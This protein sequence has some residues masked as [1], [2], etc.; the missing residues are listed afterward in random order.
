MNNAIEHRVL[1]YLNTLEGGHSKSEKL[2]KKKLR[3]EEYFVDSRFSR[4]DV[5][6]LLAL[7]TRM[8]RTIKS[9][10]PAQNKND[11][12]C[13][14]CHVQVDCQQHLPSCIEPSKHATVPIDMKYK[15][16]FGNTEKQLSI[17]GV[18]ANFSQTQ[19]ADLP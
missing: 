10:F 17:K 9:N 2:A 19:K 15:D 1:H 11:I 7:R 12:A 14:I 6:L 5:E 4:S 8:V 18:S 16:I 13:Q 3:P